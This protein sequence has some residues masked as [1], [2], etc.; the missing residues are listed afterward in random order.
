MNRQ[1]ATFARSVCQLEWQTTV[2]ILA[3]L[4]RREWSLWVSLCGRSCRSSGWGCRS[5]CWCSG[6]EWCCCRHSIWINLTN[7]VGTNISKPAVIPLTCIDIERNEN[8][9]TNLNIKTSKTLSTK[10]SKLKMAWILTF[11]ILNDELL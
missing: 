3:F 7:I 10:N 2:L 8:I 11:L 1:P 6:R 5:C 9:L 4:C